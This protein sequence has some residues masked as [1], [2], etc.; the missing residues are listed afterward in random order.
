MVRIGERVLAFTVQGVTS[1]MVGISTRDP[2]IG[3]KVLIAPT[4]DGGTVAIRPFNTYTGDDGVAMP[5]PCGSSVYLPGEP[6]NYLPASWESGFGM[7]CMQS[8]PS[9]GGWS[10]AASCP[11]SPYHGY[12]CNRGESGGSA[13]IY[14]SGFC[15]HSQYSGVWRGNKDNNWRYQRTKWYCPGGSGAA[16]PSYKIPV[17]KLVNG[18]WVIDHYE[19]CK[20]AGQDTYVRIDRYGP[21]IGSK[22]PAAGCNSPGQRINGGTSILDASGYPA[23]DYWQ[24]YGGAG[25]TCPRYNGGSGTRKCSIQN[26][27]GPAYEPGLKPTGCKYQSSLNFDGWDVGG[28]S[29]SASSGSCVLNKAT[30]GAKNSSDD[31]IQCVFSR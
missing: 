12:I 24:C 26:G 19:Y 6:A 30:E 27:K 25:G 21:T 15:I 4:G 13:D 11:I 3:Q 23:R 29:Q 10:C 8:A 14:N 20:G 7:S 16:C 2:V 22:T 5:L 9:T 17:F 1:G 28:G 18:K 31:S